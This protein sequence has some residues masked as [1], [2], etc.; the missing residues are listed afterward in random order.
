MWLSSKVRKNVENQTE[1]CKVDY[2]EKISFR[3]S[4]V[5][6]NVTFLGFSKLENLK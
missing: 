3:R 5:A 1:F 2:L 4:A 6:S